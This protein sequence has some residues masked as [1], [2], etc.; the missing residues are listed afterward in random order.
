MKTLLRLQGLWVLVE[1]G[2]KEISEPHEADEERLKEIR[3]K[4][5][6]A[7]FII[8]QAIYE[9]LFSHIVAANTSK[10]ARLILK[11]ELFGDS[12]VIKVKLQSLRRD[13]ETL[14][15]KNDY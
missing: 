8:Q 13:F 7:L 10:E 1:N 14:M 9:T 6:K 5:A 4:D 15:M 3:K 11:K 12:K 2:F